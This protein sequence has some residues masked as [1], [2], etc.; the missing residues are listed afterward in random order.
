MLLLLAALAYADPP[1]ED[2]DPYTIVVVGERSSKEAHQDLADKLGKM[3]Y[4]RKG[5]DAEGW[6][7][8]DVEGSRPTVRV[9]E[10]LVQLRDHTVSRTVDPVTGAIAA[11]ALSKRQAQILAATVLDEL[12]APMAAWRDAIAREALVHRL[13]QVDE[14]LRAA[15]DRGVGRD[16]R[17]LADAAARRAEILQ[18]WLD[19]TESDSG[20]KVRERV[21]EYVADHVEGGFSPDEIAR[22]DA[23]GFPDRIT[24]EVATA[25]TRAPKDAPRAR[26]FGEDCSFRLRPVEPGAGDQNPDW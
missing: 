17:R 20:A 14:Q 6:E 10:G 9:K 7:I 23:S 16:G 2:E 13:L 24:D 3:G 21:R 5:V 19:T 25:E 1:E 22:A 8:W 15:W 26:C 4:T 18:I 11:G 12:A